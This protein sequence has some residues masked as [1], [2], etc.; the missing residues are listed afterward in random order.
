MQTNTHLTPEHELIAPLLS[1]VDIAA[2]IS[3]LPHSVFISAS[4]VLPVHTETGPESLCAVHLQ[5]LSLSSRPPHW[6]PSLTLP[7]H[8]KNSPQIAMTFQEEG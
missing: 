4:L 5:L 6:Y 8:G 7:T 2:M 3:S 1:K